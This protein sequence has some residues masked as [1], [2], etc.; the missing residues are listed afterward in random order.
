MRV[1]A[2]AYEGGNLVLKTADAAARRFVFGFK[3]GEYELVKTK[4]RRSLDANAYAWVLVDKIASAIRLPKEEVYQNAIKGIGG[5]S[6]IVCVK[7][8]A[9]VKLRQNWSKNGLGW[10]TETIPSKIAGCTNVVLYYGSSSYDAKQ[11]GAL[12]DRLIEDA[13]AL[14]IE[15]MPPDRLEAMLSAWT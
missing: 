1:E 12:I 7:D 11:M 10:Q 5:V 6:D 14:D 9:V 13:R 4:K 8:E 2:A 15:T 3:A